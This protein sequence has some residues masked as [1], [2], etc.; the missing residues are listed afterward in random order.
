MTM[1]KSTRAEVY[2]PKVWGFS[3]LTYAEA[4]SD[5]RMP[6]DKTTKIP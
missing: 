5:R 4:S 2:L 6:R 1:V 3:G